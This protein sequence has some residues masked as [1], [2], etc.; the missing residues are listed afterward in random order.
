MKKLIKL[1]TLLITLFC[2]VNIVRARTCEDIK[3]YAQS[4]FWGRTGIYMNYSNVN[5]NYSMY[6]LKNSSGTAFS[7]YC[8]NAGIAAG[9]SYNGQ[10]FYCNKVVF[11]TTTSNE[12]R[13]TYD[14]GVI[15]ILRNGYSSRNNNKLQLAKNQE[16]AATSLALRVYEMLWPKL[17]TNGSNN[18]GNNRAHKYYV[19]KFLDD[20]EIQSLLKKSV[21]SVRSKFS[22]A[23]TVTSWKLVNSGTNVTNNVVNEAKRLVKLGLQAAVDYKTNGAATLNWNENPVKSKSPAVPDENGITNYAMSLT[24]TINVKGFKSDGAYIKMNF[25]CSNCTSNGVSYKMTINGKERSADTNLL[26]LLKNGAGTLTVKID[27]AGSSEN[28]DCSELKYKLNV[29]YYDESVSTEA[30]DMYSESCKSNTACQHFY[31][32]YADDVEQE[33]EIEDSFELCTSTCKEVQEQCAKDGAGSEACKKFKEKY[34]STC[35]ECYASLTNPPCTD[36]D[37]ELDVKEGYEVDTASCSTPSKAN[38]LE[39]IIN[40]ED[41]AGNSYKAED[42]GSNKYCSVWCKE[43][44]HFTMPGNKEVNSG[45]YFTLKASISGAKT[46]YTSAINTSQFESDLENAQHKV[47][48]SYNDY[49]F[50]KKAQEALKNE[51]ETTTTITVKYIGTTKKCSQS[52]ATC[53]ENYNN[54]KSAYDA[55]VKS[56]N[57]NRSKLNACNKECRL[58]VTCRFDESTSE[59]QQRCTEGCRSQYVKTCTSCTTCKS[60]GTVDGVDCAKTSTSS[61]TNTVTYTYKSY[62]NQFSWSGYTYTGGTTTTA[63]G[64]YT[65]ITH[66]GA[67]FT[68]KSSGSITCPSGCTKSGN[69]Y[70]CK[71]VSGTC[72]VTDGV[73]MSTMFSSSTTASKLNTLKNA[74]GVS[75]KSA[76]VFDGSGKPI[77]PPK[78]SGVPSMS[79]IGVISN[80]NY[81]SAWD[82]N[83]TFDPDIHFWYEESYMN[84]VIT[85]M[86]ETIG[87]TSVDKKAD[88]VRCAGTVDN[89]YESCSTGWTGAYLTKNVNLFVCE[90]D[91]S[92]CST[93]TF[94]VA[95]SS[96][97]KAS[98]KGSGSYITPT[99][100][101]TVYPSGAI[102]AAEPGKDIE[103]STELTNGLPVGLG[104]PAGVYNYTLIVEDLGEYYDTGKLGRIWGD[105]DSV[106]STTLK[107]EKHCYEDGALKYEVNI[108]DNYFD[109]GVYNCAYTVNCPECEVECEPDGCKDPDCPEGECPTECDPPCVYNNGDTDISYRPITNEDINPNDRELGKNWQYDEKSISTALELK[110]YATTKE[111]EEAGETIYDINFESSSDDNNFAMKVTMNSKMINKIREY[112]DKYENDYGYLNNSLKCYD[113]TQNGIT[114]KNVYCYSTFIDELLYDKNTK[115]NIKINGNRVIGTNAASTD[116]LRKTKTQTSGYWTTWAEANP[117][118]W[119][120]TTEKGL[121][122]YKTNYKDIGIGPSWK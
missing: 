44:Y 74:Y 97:M 20:K 107:E 93:K 99:Q 75:S 88:T 37:S 13:K 60:V 67:T 83:Y 21:G 70:T 2:G 81:C 27:F 85:D 90:P 62:E 58:G 30:Y 11:D 68:Y 78:S 32:L 41:Q 65:G 120:V 109:E 98:M 104:T 1:S 56:N 101:Y 24:Y 43:D 86:L 42:I 55:C 47:V 5:Y 80:Y 61:T 66:S 110:A 46:C 29:K 76:G 33:L 8:R 103:N 116:K 39:C 51:K 114:Y 40:N 121:S 52:M 72:E 102:A 95:T 100:F 118:K 3:M 50:N 119:T 53:Q 26:S 108:G 89:S 112:N 105:K 117:S 9:K 115:D 71:N 64:S 94:T 17:N 91:G 38:V 6:T 111:I 63:P 77:T 73:S 31:M 34:N 87:N 48:D 28:Y 7:S 69:T 23:T 54:C 49:T 82:M 79:L 106:V 12:T 19:N 36:D 14:A 10:K 22:N 45:R 122:Y 4:D 25:N 15:E 16:Y 35:A 59:C 84:S 113:Y 96:R 92:G 18:T 57:D